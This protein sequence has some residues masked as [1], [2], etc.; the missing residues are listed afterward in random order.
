MIKLIIFDYDGVIVDSFSA[1]HIAYQNLCKRLNLNCPTD[2]STFKKIYG[3]SSLEAN[4]N[5]GITDYAKAS[6]IFKEE[7]MKLRPRLYDGIKGVLEKLSKQYKLVILSSGYY[8][9]L[10]LKLK[11]FEIYDLFEEVYA[12]VDSA[13]RLSKREYIPLILSK[14]FVH[15]SEVFM[16]GDRD[17]D[18]EEGKAS[19]IN[20][21]ILVNYGWGHSENM[22]HPVNVPEDILYYFDI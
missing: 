13:K 9:D 18:F 21:I 14:Y 6:V 10:V 17:Y 16:V 4:Q 1:V 3:K 20:N 15:A 11:E 2:I 5:L 12:R 8:D 19:G 7:I 22:S